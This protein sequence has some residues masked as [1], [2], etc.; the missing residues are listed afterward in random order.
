M[1]LL[2]L[3]TFALSL[4]LS[5]ATWSTVPVD[6]C[7]VVVDV[8][9]WINWGG[10]AQ[11]SLGGWFWE[12]SERQSL[13]HLHWRRLWLHELATKEVCEGVRVSSQCR[14][15]GRWMDSDRT[16]ILPVR[17]EVLQRRGDE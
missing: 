12:F 3:I 6:R 1:R 13:Q 5:A 14:I 15:V 17:V 11:Y 9:H 2:R 8:S 16:V 10:N 7:D 4:S